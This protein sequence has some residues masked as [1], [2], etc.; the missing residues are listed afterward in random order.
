MG[1]ANP[2]VENDHQNS[3]M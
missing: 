2:V 3:N 1:Q